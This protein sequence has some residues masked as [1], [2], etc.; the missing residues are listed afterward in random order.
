MAGWTYCVALL[1]VKVA[2]IES[3]RILN[4]CFEGADPSASKK[5][6]ARRAYLRG[7]VAAQRVKRQ[8][9]HPAMVLA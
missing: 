7:Q 4:I 6:Q 9:L 1:D 3:T 5:Q 2:N 8:A